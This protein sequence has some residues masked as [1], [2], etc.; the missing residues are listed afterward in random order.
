MNYAVDQINEN[1]AILESIETKE[2]LEINLK[3]L[4]Q[5]IKEGNIITIKDEN[6]ILNT[7]EEIKRRNI[8]TD[9]LNRLKNLKS[10]E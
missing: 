6:Y 3:K 4:P 10:K 2:K 1:I 7:E 8:I 9:K 5:N